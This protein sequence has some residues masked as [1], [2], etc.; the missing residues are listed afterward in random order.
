MNK[1]LHSLY[2]GLLS[3]ISLVLYD[4]DLELKTYT[5]EISKTVEELN[6]WSLKLFELKLESFL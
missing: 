4:G 1:L 5:F 2:S 3:T 6:T